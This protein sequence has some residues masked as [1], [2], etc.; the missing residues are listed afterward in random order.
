MD[1]VV[2]TPARLCSLADSKTLVLS[3]IRFFVLDEA[4]ALVSGDHYV[5]VGAVPGPWIP[6]S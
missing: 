1:I 4:D 5:P 6:D 3:Q 2:G